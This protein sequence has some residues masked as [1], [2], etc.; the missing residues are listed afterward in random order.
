MSMAKVQG[1]QDAVEIIARSAKA[2]HLAPRRAS[3]NK[4]CTTHHYACD[5]REVLMCRLLEEVMQS[6]AD[7]TD[8]GYNGCDTEPC[9]WCTDARSLIGLNG[10]SSL[11]WDVL[12]RTDARSLIGSGKVTL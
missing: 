5:C 4:R 11:D 12:R 3:G 7:Q 10:S 2:D 6:H 9:Q 1:N 8:P